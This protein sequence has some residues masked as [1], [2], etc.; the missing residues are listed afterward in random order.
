MTS[1][2]KLQTVG[3]VSSFIFVFI[4][5]QVFKD[6]N[7]K[8]ISLSPIFLLQYLIVAIPILLLFVIGGSYLISTDENHNPFLSCC[9]GLAYLVAAITFMLATIKMGFII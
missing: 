7:G 1:K 3:T 4:S 8:E 5:Y 2:A 6:F 9:M